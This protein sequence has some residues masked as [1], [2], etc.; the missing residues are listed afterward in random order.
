MNLSGELREILTV[1]GSKVVDF[2]VV[3]VSFEFFHNW[4]CFPEARV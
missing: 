3:K 4:S 1:S 2:E